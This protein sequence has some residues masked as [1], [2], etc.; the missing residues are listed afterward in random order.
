MTDGEAEVESLAGE[1]P[2]GGG[3][4][5]IEQR[6]KPFRGMP[7]LQG[8]A[9]IIR[10]PQIAKP[11]AAVGGELAQKGTAI[12]R[13]D[14]GKTELPCSA[15]VLRMHDGFIRWNE[16]AAVPFRLLERRRDVDVFPLCLHRC[17]WCEANEKDVIRRAGGGGPLGDGHA[18]S[19]LGPG[20]FGVTQIFRVHDPAG[21]PKLAVDESARL[22]LVELHVGGGGIGGA[23]EGRNRRGRLR[24][25]LCLLRR[26]TQVEFL[27]F[28][29]GFSGHFL[30]KCLLI[31]CLP[32]LRSQGFDLLPLFLMSGPITRHPL[33]PRQRHRQARLVFCPAGRARRS[34]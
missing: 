26:E 5:A 32:E 15:P 20:A 3:F 18:L 25:G 29:I 2:V 22:G 16:T 28:R 24:S 6:R 23:D 19:L 27:L 8:I 21:L 31:L 11:D 17:Q 12:G 30:P 14:E 9:E 33:H 10:A 7:S 34:L 1:L 13:K 4:I